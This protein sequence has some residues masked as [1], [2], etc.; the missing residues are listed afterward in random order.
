MAQPTGTLFAGQNASSPVYIDLTEVAVV[1]Y[2]ATGTGQPLIHIVMKGGYWV[3]V[4]RTDA[5]NAALV[6]FT[7]K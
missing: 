3:E 4:P 6:P 7:G 1:E 5:N 2:C